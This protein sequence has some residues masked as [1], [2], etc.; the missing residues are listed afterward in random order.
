MS[1]NEKVEVAVV[2][3]LTKAEIQAKQG[4]ELLKKGNVTFQELKA[5]NPAYPGDVIYFIRHDPTN[6]TEVFRFKVNGITTYSLT[7]PVAPAEV[8][9]EAPAA[10]PEPTENVNMLDELLSSEIDEGVSSEQEEVDESVA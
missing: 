9:A 8:V 5:I 7:A 6:P 3:K 1:E 2:K 10:V 4:L